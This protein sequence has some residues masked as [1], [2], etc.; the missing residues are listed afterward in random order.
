MSAATLRGAA[1]GCPVERSFALTNEH[2]LGIVFKPC[3]TSA[4]LIWGRGSVGRAL[5]SHGRGRRFDSGRLHH[6]IDVEAQPLSA[7]APRLIHTAKEGPACVHYS[8]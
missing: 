2:A 8:S 6:G 1:S 5:P 3:R 7:G 4:G